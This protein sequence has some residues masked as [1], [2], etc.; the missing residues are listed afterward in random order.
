MS[1]ELLTD[2]S[3]ALDANAS[4]LS[5]AKWY[6]YVTATTT[7]Q[8]V[9]TTAALNIAHSNPVVADAGGKFAPIYFDGEISYRGVLKDADDNT[10]QDI[11]PI[12]P[13]LGA[14]LGGRNE[15]NGF[16]GLD[17]TSSARVPFDLRVG[18]PSFDSG[19][20]YVEGAGRIR[21]GVSTA[22]PDGLLY[23]RQEGFPADYEEGSLAMYPVPANR[24]SGLSIA[25]SGDPWNLPTENVSSVA[26]Q[27]RNGASEERLAIGAKWFGGSGGYGLYRIA[28]FKNGSGQYWDLQL[29]NADAVQQ[30]IS[31]TGTVAFTNAK[32]SDGTAFG[33][34]VVD[35][36]NPSAGDK[37][38]LFARTTGEVGIESVTGGTSNWEMRMSGVLGGPQVVGTQPGFQLS[39]TDQGV[40]NKRWFLDSAGG[41]LR[42]MAGNDAGNSFGH[43]WGVS[44][45]G[46]SVAEFS[47]FGQVGSGVIR[48]H[49]NEIGFYGADPIV[50]PSV[51]GAKGG[52][53]ALTS[54]LS[55]LATLGLIT[56]STT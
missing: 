25:P 17:S 18:Q 15:A 33:S 38:R 39:E 55:Q 35:V 51:T 36:A 20:N 4:P 54:L 56:D 9:Y 47:L 30:I 50:K 8:S 34:T 26:L 42:L 27:L 21:V 28:A 3:R 29:S 7:P 16:V 52:N 5:G 6:F 43:I 41:Q 2:A 48:L 1:A 10:I 13:A 14:I 22:Y 49:P 23:L 31:R 46:A 12:N 44:R 40:D 24:W 19:G 37:M 32:V 53:A 45:S 11:D